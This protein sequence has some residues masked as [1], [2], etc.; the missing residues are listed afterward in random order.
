MAVRL[1]K[2]DFFSSQRVSYEGR[3]V[4]PQVQTTAFFPSDIIAFCCC[5]R[6]HIL[7]K[8]KKNGEIDLIFLSFFYFG[9]TGYILLPPPRGL[10]PVDRGSGQVGNTFSVT[11]I[12]C[13]VL[14]LFFVSGVIQHTSLPCLV[15]YLVSSLLVLVKVVSGLI[16]IR[17][18]T[19][20]S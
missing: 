20:S 16:V 5:Q 2:P 14:K 9:R 1:I 6:F 11:F 3:Q 13:F 18:L 10:V 15:W 17:K 4:L 8:K 7:Q 19:G 12:G